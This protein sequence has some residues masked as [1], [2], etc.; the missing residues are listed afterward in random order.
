MYLL[1]EQT[2][3]DVIVEKEA[4]EDRDIFSF[5]TPRGSAFCVSKIHFGSFSKTII[6]HQ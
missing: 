2:Y 3:I 4:F 5:H 6:G 1:Y